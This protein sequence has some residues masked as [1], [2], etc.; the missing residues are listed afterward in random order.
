MENQ[1]LCASPSHS[2][3]DS[4]SGTLHS[5]LV[6]IPLATFAK[7]CLVR[8]RLAQ[9]TISGSLVCHSLSQIYQNVTLFFNGIL[10]NFG[11]LRVVQNRSRELAD[12]AQW[13]AVPAVVLVARATSHN[14]GYATCPSEH[15]NA[16]PATIAYP[17]AIARNF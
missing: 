3:E 7:K 5:G 14:S 17:R 11:Y 13:R 10:V 15:A 6:S 8:F 2:S 9:H 4:C 12:F 1:K 16:R